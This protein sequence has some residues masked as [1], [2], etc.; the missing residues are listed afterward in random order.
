MAITAP[1]PRAEP[2]NQTSGANLWGPGRVLFNMNTEQLS[3]PFQWMI[4]P[5]GGFQQCGQTRK[6]LPPAGYTCHQ[7]CYGRLELHAQDLLA[8]DYIDFPHGL[9]SRVLRE[10]GQFWSLKENFQ[11]F[12]FL[13]RRGFLFYG[14]QGCGKSSLIH[15]I[16]RGIVAAGHVAFFCDNPYVFLSTMTEFRRVEPSR[17]LV[18]VFEDLDAIIKR[19]GD[20]ALLQWLDGNHQ[21]DRVVNLASTNYPE[22]LDRRIVSRP[23]RFD[24]ILR[25]DAPDDR[26]RAA[27]FARKMPEQSAAER[28]Q[29]VELTD[30]LPFAALAELVI[31]VQCLGNHLEET[32]ALLKKLDA[33][34]PSSLEFSDGPPPDSEPASEQADS[35]YEKECHYS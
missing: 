20:A 30:G 12:G 9:P 22:R 2:Q 25:I 31:S 32:I 21:V 19:Y 35:I 23:R 18:C 4:L 17:P 15:Q 16:V 7:D 14:K 24:R 33:Q 1:K 13:H 3:H 34:S 29:W 8:D 11:R 5:N 10:I 6:L 27:Y 26:F 28:A